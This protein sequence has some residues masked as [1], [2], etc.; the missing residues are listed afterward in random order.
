LKIEAAWTIVDERDR[1]NRSGAGPPTFGLKW[2]FVDETRRRPAI[3]VYPQW[4]PHVRHGPFADEP[5]EI[6][7]PLEV[8]KRFGRG[9]LAFET[10]YDFLQG[11]ADIWEAGLLSSYT[12][13]PDRFEIAGELHG[14]LPNEWIADAGLRNRFGKIV[15]VFFSAGRGVLASAHTTPRLVAS[16]GLQLSM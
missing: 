6:F 16:L 4:T 14:K 2:R 15:S 13:V 9:A 8:R 3:S 1:P 5:R 12:L 10:G 11:S 7:L